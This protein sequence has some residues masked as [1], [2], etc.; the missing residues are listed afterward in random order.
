MEP[1]IT[2]K[3]RLA[4]GK[5]PASDAS[6]RDF[7]LEFFDSSH[8]GRVGGWLGGWIGCHAVTMSIGDSLVTRSMPSDAVHTCGRAGRGLCSQM[9]MHSIVR[10]YVCV[11]SA[12]QE[13]TLSV[14]K[15]NFDSATC[16][17]AKYTKTSA[18]AKLGVGQKCQYVCKTGY[19]S[20][21]EAE[22]QCKVNSVKTSAEGKWDPPRCEGA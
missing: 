3:A 5:F 10:K 15:L 12:V 11:C 17:S 18:D 21:K 13:C 9:V 19:H 7:V 16:S 8:F 1:T 22:M 4:N 6:V 2:K 14:Q 20:T